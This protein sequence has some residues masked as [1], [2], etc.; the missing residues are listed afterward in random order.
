M[1]EESINDLIGAV[2]SSVSFVH[3]YL[4]LH[5]DRQILRFLIMPSLENDKKVIPDDD[6]Y[7]NR[8]CSL[9]G[10]K[11]VSLEIEEESHLSVTF[12]SGI[13]LNVAAD[14]VNEPEFVHYVSVE[15][16]PIQVW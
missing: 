6:V 14:P 4:E 16:G 2:V 13:M 3:N 8:L 10:D 5:F 12:D 15:G 1:K 7:Q 11:I 9:I